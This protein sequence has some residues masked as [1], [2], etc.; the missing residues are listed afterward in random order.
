MDGL[1]RAADTPTTSS[2]T[3]YTDKK[4][5][6]ACTDGPSQRL[7]ADGGEPVDQQEHT[8]LA[9]E[10]EGPVEG[11]RLV[12]ALLDGGV[13]QFDEATDELSLDPEVRAAWQESIE[14]YAALEP[15]EL[16]ARI[17]VLAGLPSVDTLDE[18]NAI[19]YSLR[20][21]EGGVTST[22]TRQVAV[23]EI[24]ALEAL[25]SF[26]DD[27]DV[28]RQAVE[29]LRMFLEQCPVCDTD[30]VETDTLDCCGGLV[31]PNQEPQQ[32]LA[33]PTCDRRLYTFPA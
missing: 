29:P 8:S 16:G 27:E 32:V 13:L 4:M 14:R 9:Q 30:L 19:W 24:A 1:D 28:R 2:Q 15:E 20:P 25:E 10:G 3:N 22:L 23:A 11:E 31:N 21:E 12:G 17:R 26:V 6:D 33:C 18:G 5:M 7:L